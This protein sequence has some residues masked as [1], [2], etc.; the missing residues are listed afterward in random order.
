MGDAKILM[1]GRGI[2][3]ALAPAPPFRRHQVLQ[4]HGL[5]DTRYV[6]SGAE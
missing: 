3:M 6:P 4:E 5:W 1:S 2:F